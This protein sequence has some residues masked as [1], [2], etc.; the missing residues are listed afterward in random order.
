MTRHAASRARIA[1]FW[2]AV[3]ATEAAEP[4]ACLEW[5]GYRNAKGYGWTKRKQRSLLVPRAVW[6]EK[7]GE[8]PTG[9]HVL[10]RC[11]NPPCARPAHLFLG[12]PAEN[13]A[14]MMAKGRHVAPTGE[15]N[16]RTTL[17]EAVLDELRTRWAGGATFKALA[18]EFRIHPVTVSRICRGLR[19]SS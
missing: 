14:D 13:T 9:L 8:I 4:G 17:S 7:H 2:L 15:R 16:G 6:I 10:H 12:T 3:N 19:R 1:A 11:D 5:P 18:R